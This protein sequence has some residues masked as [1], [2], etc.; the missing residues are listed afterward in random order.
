MRGRGEQR[1]DYTGI[2]PGRS[3]G[4]F[5]T[6]MTA[7]AV[8]ELHVQS[9]NTCEQSKPFVALHQALTPHGT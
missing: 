2:L 4:K 9:M 1:E 6:Q 5:M 8:G 7:E 3:R